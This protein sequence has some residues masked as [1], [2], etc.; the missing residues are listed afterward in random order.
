MS[1]DAGPKSLWGVAEGH[2]L[3][4]ISQGF[5]LQGWEPMAWLYWKNKFGYE[6]GGDILTG[7]VIID[8]TSIAQWETFVR[9]IFGDESYNSQ[10]PW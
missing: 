9:G 7:P 2:L 4:T 6:P 5:W 3:S 1:V 10:N 8:K